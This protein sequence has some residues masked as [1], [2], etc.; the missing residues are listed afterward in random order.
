[1]RKC[2]KVFIKILI[3]AALFAKLVEVLVSYF[4]GKAYNIM[5][6]QPKEKAKE[7][8]ETA[9][10]ICWLTAMAQPFLKVIKSQ[11]SFRRIQTI[12]P[13][14]FNQIKIEISN[15]DR[16]E[17][18]K[19]ED[20]CNDLDFTVEIHSILYSKKWYN[21]CLIKFEDWKNRLR[22]STSIEK[23][24]NEKLFISNF[25]SAN[26]KKRQNIFAPKLE[27]RYKPI[28]LNY[29]LNEYLPCGIAKF[30]ISLE[31]E[32]DLDLDNVLHLFGKDIFN[33]LHLYFHNHHYHD[34]VN[35]HNIPFY[36]KEDINL[37]SRNNKAL[38]YFLTKMG[39]GFSDMVNEVYLTYK[40]FLY[41]EKHPQGDGKKKINKKTRRK[42][43]KKFYKNCDNL[44]GMHVFLNAI[45]SAPQNT[46]WKL[47][48]SSSGAV[49]EK[50]MGMAVII[51]N[52]HRGT[53]ALMRKISH[54]QDDL[55][56]T[57][58]M[59]AAFWGIWVSVIMGFLGVLI[60]IE[61]TKNWLKD[62][63]NWV[64]NGCNSVYDWIVCL[65]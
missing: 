31:G 27:M 12:D 55:H 44:L 50:R 21:Q 25:N 11:K 8:L 19:E 3:F 58:S 37:R 14:E 1:M 59:K 36:P 63:W 24:I 4:R 52:S 30:K 33:M 54:H 47:D 49:D 64:W 35:P 57:K 40:D 65:L 29:R 61:T 5:S 46:H 13:A 9:V 39:N 17:C 26:L 32:S 38:E 45:L 16:L 22:K 2:L 18:V 15:P 43:I 34:I 48:N 28:R 53:E 42:S 56:Y 23:E 51:E 60:S 20:V 6:D 10:M 7:T 62:L 41:L